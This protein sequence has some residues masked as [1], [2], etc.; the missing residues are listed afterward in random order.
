MPYRSR[1]ERARAD[2][3]A[4]GLVADMVR[5]FA[6][7]YAFIREL[8]QNGIDAGATAIEVR[9]AH[10]PD[11]VAAISVAD[12]GAGMTRAIIEGP[13][14]TLFNSEKDGDAT[15]IG[16]YGVG[17]VS[18]FALDPDEVIVETWRDGVA[19]RLTLAPDHSY[20][21]AEVETPR[22]AKTPSG[23]IVSVQRRMDVDEHASHASSARA[24]LLRWCRHARLPIFFRD[25]VGERERI[26]RELDVEAAHRVRVERE[27]LT[28]VVGAGGAGSFGGFYHRGLTLHETTALSSWLDGLQFKIDSPALQHTLSRDNLRHDDGY[29]GVMRELRSIVENTLPREIV[30]RI[31]RIARE[32]ANSGERVGDHPALLAAALTPCLEIDAGDLELPLASPVGGATTIPA[33]K[34]VKA[35]LGL[36]APKGDALTE[37]LAKLGRPVWQTDDLTLA[38]RLGERVGAPIVAASDVFL[39]VVPVECA[40]SDEALVTLVDEH[41]RAAGAKT[42]SVRLVTL[43]G[44]NPKLAGIAIGDEPVVLLDEARRGWLR[45]LGATPLG[46]V[47]KHRAVS[48]A[49]RLAAHD[50]AR[51]AHLLAR[52]LLVEQRGAIGASPNDALLASVVR[53]RP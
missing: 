34:L 32:S 3:P 41:L 42:P 37:A 38:V 6:D 8:V 17:F 22:G 5:Q 45:W 48:T 9:V 43:D 11:G 29:H 2:A 20:E 33:T 27:G 28:I 40:A 53:A 25:G 39:R 35:K 18:V 24:A 30:A 14:L 44:A 10:R 15:K 12:D 19:H 1:K 26:D 49:R 52:Y 46:L 13:L 31:R 50:A 21:L 51:A 47:V 7:R 23:T 4:E 36:R 16:K